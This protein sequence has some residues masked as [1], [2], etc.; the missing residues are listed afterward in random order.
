MYRKLLDSSYL[1]RYALLNAVDISDYLVFPSREIGNA[2]PRFNFTPPE[3]TEALVPLLNQVLATRSQPGRT[4]T[5][6]QYLERNRT[7]AFLVIQH[8]RLLCERYYNGYDHDS[9]CTSFSVAKSFVSA[10]IGTALHE[11]LIGNL[12]DPLTKYLPELKGPLWQAITIRHLISMSS[13]IAYKRAGFFPWNDQPRIYYSLDLRRLALH[14]RPVGTPGT[15]FLYNNYNLLLLGMVLERVTG[16]HVSTYLQ[17][18]IWKPLGMEWPATWSMD[19]ERCGMEKME[20]GLNAR[21]VDFARFGRLYLRCGDWNG[22]QLIPEE[23]VVESTT[24][25]ADGR[26]TNH[27]YFWWIAPSGKGRFMAIG[28]H[29]QFIYVAPDKDCIILRF[30]RGKPRDWQTAYVELWGAI[31]EAL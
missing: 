14:A 9:I 27:K 16:G 6:D 24:P 29:G 13:G 18:R 7:A 28:S 11:K 26:W 4:E 8:D 2:A 20:S 10:M 23:W 12:D 21:A 31:A 3:D 25:W 19:S 15:H 5:I 22:R 17:E 1:A 30:G